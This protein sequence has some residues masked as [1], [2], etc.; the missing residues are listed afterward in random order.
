MR[1]RDEHV[2]SSVRGRGRLVRLLLAH[3]PDR[4]CTGPG[5]RRPRRRRTASATFR[6]G[7]D[8]LPN[9]LAAQAKLRRRTQSPRLLESG[10]SRP[11][12]RRRNRAIRDPRQQHRAPERAAL[13]PQKGP[14]GP[15]YPTST[16]RNRS[17][18]SHAIPG[19]RRW[20]NATRYQTGPMKTDPA[21]DP[22]L[23]QQRDSARQQHLR[24]GEL[25][26]TRTTA[27][28]MFGKGQNVQGLL[29]QAEPRGQRA[30][31]RGDDRPAR[32]SLQRA[33]FQRPHNPVAGDS[34]RTDGL[35][36]L[37][38]DA[39]PGTTRRRRPARPDAQSKTYIKQFRQGRPLRLTASMKP[40]GY[41]V[42]S[43]PSH[44][45]E[46]R[47]PISRA[48][49]PSGT[50]PL[51]C[52]LHRLQQDRPGLQQGRRRN[53]NNTG[54]WIGDCCTT[55]PETATSGSSPPVR[56]RPR[57]AQTTAG[58]RPAFRHK[59]ATPPSGR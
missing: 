25:P 48:R 21:V 37:R 58:G 43:R 1:K 32:P 8:S 17:S 33:R 24:V 53:H 31:G 34:V 49:T 7:G 42:P 15:R 16:R 3:A 57:P 52:L 26:T 29:P 20:R 47:R 54:I 35:L 13:P 14:L 44:A 23:G 19:A 50:P 38:Q 12:G 40:D 30:P 18:P 46:G 39:A 2:R 6:P 10:R 45:G 56:S 27:N 28:M 9:P 5:H 11:R 59:T 41:I 4:A 22:Q 36:E 55:E 51:V